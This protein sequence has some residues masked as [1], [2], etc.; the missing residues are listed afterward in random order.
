MAVSISA[1]FVALF[2]NV[3]RLTKTTYGIR[4]DRIMKSLPGKIQVRFRKDAGNN[5]LVLFYFIF[6]LNAIFVNVV[7]MQDILIRILTAK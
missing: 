1:T 6:S 5:C 4:R 3:E 7:T 2:K